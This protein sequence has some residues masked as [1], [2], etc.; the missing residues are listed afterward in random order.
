MKAMT[1]KEEQKRENR[2]GQS[3]GESRTEENR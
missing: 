3:R 2:A 1:Y